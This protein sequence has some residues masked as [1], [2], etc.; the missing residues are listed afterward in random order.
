MPRQGSSL[1]RDKRFTSHGPLAGMTLRI[2]NGPSQSLANRFRISSALGDLNRIVPV[3]FVHKRKA[4]VKQTGRALPLS[5]QY[6]PYSGTP[7][8]P[9]PVKQRQ[10][11]IEGRRLDFF[12]VSMHGIAGPAAATS[13]IFSHGPACI[14]FEIAS[15]VIFAVFSAIASRSSQVSPKS[16]ALDTLLFKSARS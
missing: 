6:A 7:K 2:D 4:A 1:A 14:P 9:H 3:L 10:N 16:G 15:K 11:L 13:V 8:P 12:K 5:R